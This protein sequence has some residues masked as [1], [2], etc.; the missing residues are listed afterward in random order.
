MADSIKRIK[1]ILQTDGTGAFVK[2]LKDAKKAISDL[3]YEQARSNKFLDKKKDVTKIFGN[4]LEYAR[5][6]AKAFTDQNVALTKNNERLN[7]AIKD[8]ATAF[9]EYTGQAE[10]MRGKQAKAKEVLQEYNGKVKAQKKLVSDL[11]I[12][13]KKQKLVVD[14]AKN[15]YNESK[16][17]LDK[18]RDS[19]SALYKAKRNGEKV[20]NKALQNMSAELE[21]RK[22]TTNELKAEHVAKENAWLRDKDRYTQADAKLK[23]MQIQQG[24]Y[25]DEVKK[26]TKAVKDLEDKAKQAN[27]TTA[28]ASQLYEENTEKIKRNKEA[29]EDLARTVHKEYTEWRNAGGVLAERAEKWKARGKAVTDFSN[30]L[31]SLGSTFTRKLTVPIVAGMGFAGKAYLEFQDQ[32]IKTT[33]LLNGNSKSADRLGKS[34]Q[35]LATKWGISG[36]KIRDAQM[37]LIKKGFTANQVM[38]AMPSILKATV[39]SGDDFVHVMDTSSSVMAQFGLMS[40]STGKMLKN[41]DRVTSALLYSANETAAGFNDIGEAMKNVGAMAHTNNQSIEDTAILLGLLS[42]AGIKGGMAGTYL[43]NILKDLN[44]RTKNTKKAMKQLGIE[45]FDAHG[46]MKPLPEVL[47]QINEKTKG[48]TDQQKYAALSAIFSTRSMKGLLPLLSQM[49]PEYDRLAEGIKKAGDYQDKVAKKMATSAKYQFQ[50]FI[51]S[52]RVVGE[53]FGKEIVP[54]LTSGMKKVGKAMDWFGNLSSGWKKAIVNTGLLLA[55]IGPVMKAFG[56][57]GKIIGGTMSGYGLLTGVVGKL[58]TKKVTLAQVSKFLARS[59]IDETLSL[60][61]ISEPTRRS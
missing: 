55:S 40:K 23:D 36:V 49:G 34:S 21:A 52:A 4:N 16:I 1:V 44:G 3:D 56:G 35:N 9:K 20:D 46:K 42:N 15:A 32:V 53:K 29:T 59:T 28:A 17:E 58:I 30:K 19:Y 33:A 26:T 37:E 7:E 48:M 61:H 50:K 5:R 18:T 13:Q 11:N 6:K 10:E 38:G 24:K 12:V 8:S 47:K 14:K 43:S 60:I 25:S 51:E 31:S 39:A 41:T 54:Y 27:N 45:A 2:S 22:K 57:L